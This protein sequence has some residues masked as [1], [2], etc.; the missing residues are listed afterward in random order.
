[1]MA[2]LVRQEDT[3]YIIEHEKDGKNGTNAL[4]EHL[5]YAIT[6]RVHCK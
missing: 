4:L 5:Q 2:E 1:M 6:S 3:S